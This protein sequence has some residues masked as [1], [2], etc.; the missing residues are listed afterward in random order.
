MS[1]KQYPN[2]RQ[3][4]RGKGR[5]VVMPHAGQH[6]VGMRK[7]TILDPTNGN[8]FSGISGSGAAP[9]ANSPAIFETDDED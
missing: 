2:P 6:S 8:T 1:H 7:P 3:D 5:A 4:R 9:G